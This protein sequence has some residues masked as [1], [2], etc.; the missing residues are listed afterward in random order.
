[1]SR[2]RTNYAAGLGE[3]IQ[4]V[5]PKLCADLGRAPTIAEVREAVIEQGLNPSHTGVKKALVRL[6]L[7]RSETPITSAKK[8]AEQTKT[9]AAPKKTPERSASTRARAVDEDPPASGGTGALLAIMALQTARSK[10]VGEL[11]AIDAVIARL[12]P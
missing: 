1:M 11:E 6:E 8:P 12:R 4:E 5:H 3:C 10:L 9:K 7:A 2:T